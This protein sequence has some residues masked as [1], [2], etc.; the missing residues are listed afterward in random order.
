MPGADAA[1]QGA[2]PEAAP[3]ASQDAGEA[4][5]ELK[6]PASSVQASPFSAAAAGMSRLG[7]HGRTSTVS[8]SM[9]LTAAQAP[10]TLK[11]LSL[12]RFEQQGSGVRN[13]E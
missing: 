11:S 1:A 8:Q 5:V 13:T 9:P 10:E 7:S 2:E 6:Q 12:L 4:A 3:E